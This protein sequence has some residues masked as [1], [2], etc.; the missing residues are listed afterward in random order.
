MS[1]FT[2]GYLI[3]TAI[4]LLGAVIVIYFLVRRPSA[5]ALK[6]SLMRNRYAVPGV[7]FIT[8]G[9]VVALNEFGKSTQPTCNSAFSIKNS[10]DCYT[11]QRRVFKVCVGNGGGSN[12]LSGADARYDCLSYQALGGGG[13]NTYDFLALKYCGYLD[14]GNQKV[15]PNN[16]TVIQNNAGGECGWT[17]F[18]VTCNP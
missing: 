18:Q 6:S 5:L 2:Y 4:L 16:V 17:S 11:K 3:E 8:I 10:V 1:E 12:C 9:L 15:A 7:I 14:N 13:K